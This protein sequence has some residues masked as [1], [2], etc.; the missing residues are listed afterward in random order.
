MVMDIVF[1]LDSVITACGLSGQILVMIPAVIIAV[2]IMIIFADPISD[3]INNNPEIKVVALVFVMLV[4]VM[5][6]LEGFYLEEVAG[7]PLN[8]ILYILMVLGLV[9]AIVKMLK[10]RKREKAAAA[11]ADPKTE[12]DEASKGE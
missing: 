7:I 9:V 4:G 10:R 3:F 6:V 8:A 12:A 5:L 2:S 11:D 1:S